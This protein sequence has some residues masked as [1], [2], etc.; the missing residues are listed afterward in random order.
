MKFHGMYSLLRVVHMTCP[1]HIDVSV[2]LPSSAIALMDPAPVPSVPRARLLHSL[3]GFDQPVSGKP[4]TV[5]VPLVASSARLLV[6]KSFGSD[7]ATLPFTD[8]IVMVELSV[9]NVPCC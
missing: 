7:S 9:M 2:R 8:S 1:R 6:A 4:L 3:P 5:H